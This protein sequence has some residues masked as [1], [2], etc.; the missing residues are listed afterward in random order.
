MN[1]QDGTPCSNIMVVMT[2][3]LR[4]HKRIDYTKT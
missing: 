4:K 1:E 3:K 2:M